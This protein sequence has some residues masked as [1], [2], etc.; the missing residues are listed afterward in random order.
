MPS[1]VL[2]RHDQDDG[3]IHYEIWDRDPSTYHRLCTIVEDPIEDTEYDELDEIDRGQAL[4]DARLILKAL[5][6]YSK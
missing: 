3:A 4:K 2:E 5:V 6:A 1:Y